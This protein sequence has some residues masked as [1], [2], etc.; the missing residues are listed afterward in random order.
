M[1]KEKIY[2]DYGFI[3]RR[4]RIALNIIMVC[5]GL[6][7]LG[8]WKVQ[9]LD[10][11]KYLS[12]S[13][14]NHLRETV[15]PAPRGYFFDR[16]G[17]ILADNIAS[18]KACLIRENNPNWRNSLSR[19]AGLLKLDEATLK[20]RIEK[21]S[22]QPLFFPIVLKDHLSLEEVTQVEARRLEFPELAIE[23]EP[24]RFYPFGSLAAH[25]L[26]YLQE[27]S[28][29]E[30]NSGEFKPKSFGELVGKTGLERIY[31]RW[32]QGENGKRRDIVDSLGRIHGEYDRVEPKPG[33][34]IH[35]T[36]DFDLQKKCEAMLQDREGA[37][38]VLDP[39]TGEILAMASYPTFDPNKF[40]TRFTPQEWEELISR[41][42]HPLENRALR[43]LY[44]PGSMFKLTVALAALHYK[45]ITP[46]T[47]FFCSGEANFYGRSFSCWHK[48]G[49]GWL[50][51]ADA[52][53]DSCNVYFY[54][55]GR[56]LGIERLSSFA[57]LLGFGSLTGIDLPG[58][59]EGLIPDPAWKWRT[60]RTKWFGGETISVAIGQG[61]IHVTPLQMA[62][63]TALLANRGKKVRPH[64]TKDKLLALPDNGQEEN[65]A[66]KGISTAF[67]EPVIEGMWRSVN[68]S[69]TGHL[70]QVEGLDVCGKTGSTQIISLEKAEKLGQTIKPHSWFTGFAPRHYPRI[71][72]TVVVEYGGMGGE[73]ASPIAREIF[74]LYKEKYLHD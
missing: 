50:T 6:L 53:R 39:T 14:A 23:H 19:L 40:V 12:L 74:A 18:F 33:Q 41:A 55:V 38:V 13:E 47:A 28:P 58:E 73:T 37:I 10:Y 72:V 17:V 67:F 66:E 42:D 44:A 57:R 36:L 31:E 8:Y 4:T 15:I 25:V 7:A 45:I 22:S 27:I 46:Q 65:L 2:E 56:R 51:L 62:V 1:F 48:G 43:G 70:A 30:V 24:R 64:L 29:E 59:K 21:Y 16:N 54:N 71:V 20:A 11:Q 26:G 34:D 9:I 35:L 60:Q 61:P 63:H 3:H 52:I 5:F 49:H 69:G 68:A 32:L